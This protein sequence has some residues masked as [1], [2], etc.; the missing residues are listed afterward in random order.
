MACAW[1]GVAGYGVAMLMSYFVGQKYYPINYP[2][3]DLFKYVLLTVVLYL[4]IGVSSHYLTIVPELIVNTLLCGVFVFYVL[5]KDLPLAEIPVIGKLT[6]IP[7]V[8][9]IFGTGKKK[10][11]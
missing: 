5:K 3:G 10:S 9:K 1:A 11:E 6:R 4:A 7:I 8:G 2:I